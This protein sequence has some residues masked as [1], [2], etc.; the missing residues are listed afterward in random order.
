VLK[1][2]K[3]D[4]SEKDFQHGSNLRRYDCCEK[5]PVRLCTTVP[6]IAAPGGA[7]LLI[8]ICYRAQRLPRDALESRAL[9]NETRVLLIEMDDKVVPKM[10]EDLRAFAENAFRN[11][12]LSAHV[13]ARPVAA[14][15]TA[16]AEHNRAQTKINRRE[17]FELLGP[18]N[19][20]GF[21]L[22]SEIFADTRRKR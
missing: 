19:A 5:E 7:V 6:K 10:G 20:A 12:A 2:T 16:T 4:E 18:A 13:K 9:Q 3:S 11:R 14:A 8:G 21:D 1:R 22:T 15:K 17:C